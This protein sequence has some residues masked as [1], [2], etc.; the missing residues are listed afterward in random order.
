MDWYVGV[1]FTGH[2]DVLLV[3]SGLVVTV[4]ILGVALQVAVSDVQGRAALVAVALPVLAGDIFLGADGLDICQGLM[5]E[6]VHG[7]A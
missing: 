3:L 7:L 6:G 5:H 2:N 1:P 4:G